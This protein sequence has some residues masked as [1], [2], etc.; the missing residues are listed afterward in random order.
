MSR[1]RLYTEAQVRKL[2][3]AAGVHGSYM[4]ILKREGIRPIKVDDKRHVPR[5]AQDQIDE[6][7]AMVNL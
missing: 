3:K 6:F 7:I 4:A 1:Q 5:Y 2:F